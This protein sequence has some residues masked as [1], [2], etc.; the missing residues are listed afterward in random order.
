ML[1]SFSQQDPRWATRKIGQTQQTIGRVGCLITCLSDIST[2][3]GAWYSPLAIENVCKF[4][5]DA[6]LFWETADFSTFKFMRR[7]RVYDADAVA[8]AMKDPAW[9]VAL[10]VAHG[11]HWVVPL[12]W[13]LLFNCYKIA[14]PFFGDVSTM[15]RYANSITG[16]AFFKRK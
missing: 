12:S 15:R 1:L 10:E 14:D 3:F 7:D 2:Y 9:A 16:A 5:S 13:S 6:K 4:N 11:S 8:R